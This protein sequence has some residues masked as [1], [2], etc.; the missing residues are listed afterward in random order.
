MEDHSNDQET[1]LR[2]NLTV[3]FVPIEVPT[4]AQTGAK[5][6]CNVYPRTWDIEIDDGVYERGAYRGTKAVPLRVHMQ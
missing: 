3:Q 5:A 2:C 1:N 6:D 4:V